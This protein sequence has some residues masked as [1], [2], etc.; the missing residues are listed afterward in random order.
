[1][2]LRN[3]CLGIRFEVAVRILLGCG[4]ASIMPAKL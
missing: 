4:H 3:L 1:L 2:R